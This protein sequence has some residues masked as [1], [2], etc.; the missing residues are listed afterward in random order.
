[1]NLECRAKL[2]KFV[3]CSGNWDIDC[4]FDI[5]HVAEIA[6]DYRIEGENA[7]REEFGKILGTN[8]SDSPESDGLE[9][10]ARYTSEGK[11]GI[12]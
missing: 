1:M 7:V 3:E 9:N 6:N 5:N 12:V 4:D 8:I 11:G 10:G 2:I